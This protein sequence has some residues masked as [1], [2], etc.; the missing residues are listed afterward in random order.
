MK[1]PSDPSD[2]THPV[3][4]GD[5]DL[6]LCPGPGEAHPLAVPKFP[7]IPFARLE[8]ETCHKV[9]KMDEAMRQRR[10]APDPLKGPGATT[11]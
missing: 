5:C 9:V 7:G 6:V 2:P 4:A 8:C 3:Q 10:W 11:D 1:T